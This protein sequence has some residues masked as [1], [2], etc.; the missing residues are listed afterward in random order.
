MSMVGYSIIITA[1]HQVFTLQVGTF[2]SK[3][4]KHTILSLSREF[5]KNY[6]SRHCS[7]L[8][9]SICVARE[10]FR[11]HTPNSKSM[12]N[13]PN[14]Q[15]HTRHNRRAVSIRV[16]NYTNYSTRVR[17]GANSLVVVADQRCDY[18]FRPAGES[19]QVVGI[20]DGHGLDTVCTRRSNKWFVFTETTNRPAT[21]YAISKHR[22]ANKFAYRKKW[23]CPMYAVDGR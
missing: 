20:S 16:D 15:N 2:Y 17:P 9:V 4:A 1:Q 5:R 10:Y 7:T 8:Y 13:R 3:L 23:V 11:H 22:Y 12:P 6:W 21:V 19:A 18:T 14:V